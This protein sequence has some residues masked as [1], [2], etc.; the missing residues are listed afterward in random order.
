MAEISSKRKYNFESMYPNPQKYNLKYWERMQKLLD[1][2]ETRA[3]SL[4][5]RHKWIERQNKMN[6]QNE[7]DRLVGELHKLPPG[8]IKHAID[9]AMPKEKLAMVNQYTFDS[10]KPDTSM[11]GTRGSASTRSLPKSTASSFK[12]GASKADSERTEVAA[13]MAGEQYKELQGRWASMAPRRQG[14]GGAS[15]S[16]GTR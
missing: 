4:L 14:K 11:R 8:F 10:T 2:R 5:L 3:Q 12:S 7:Y 16:S 9:Q 15:S 6:Y 1:A 13:A